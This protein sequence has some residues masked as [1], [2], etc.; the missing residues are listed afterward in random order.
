MK[1]GLVLIILSMVLLSRIFIAIWVYKDA[2]SRGINPLLWT[3][4]VLVYSGALVFLMYFLVIRKERNITCENCSYVQSEKLLYCGRCGSEIKIDKYE[5]RFNKDSN[6]VFL[7]IGIILLVAGIFLG[8]T[9]TVQTVWKDKH[10]LPISIMSLQSKYGG[11][12]TNSFRYKNGGGSHSYKIKDKTILNSSWDVEDG[13]I[14]AKLYN[15]D[16][17]IKEINSEDNPKYE[18]LIDLSEYKESRVVLK[19]KFKKASG[20][21]KFI[22][23]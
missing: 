15:D 6:K 17:L 12:W 23:E 14:E 8:L 9:F 1:I 20:K 19:L 21:F 10:N 2:K 22:L 16:K 13:N 3:I 11:K 18:E 4:L 7:N 5:E